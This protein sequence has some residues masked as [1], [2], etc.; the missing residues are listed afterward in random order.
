MIIAC[1][2]CLW[3]QHSLVME[4]KQISTT[5]VSFYTL[6]SPA[7]TKTK[8]YTGRVYLEYDDDWLWNL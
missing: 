2:K 5:G 3:Q 6:C 4:R 1:E 7:C 8:T